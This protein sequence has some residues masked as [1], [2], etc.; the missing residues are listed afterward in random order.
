MAITDGSMGPD[1]KIRRFDPRKIVKPK[2]AEARLCIG[3]IS[4]VIEEYNREESEG[5]DPDPEKYLNDILN[6][7]KCY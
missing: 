6:I 7:R 3:L 1:Y 2:Q 4:E 5:K